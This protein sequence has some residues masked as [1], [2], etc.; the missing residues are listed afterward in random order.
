MYVP[1]ACIAM[2]HVLL[3]SMIPSIETMN[4]KLHWTYDGIVEHACKRRMNMNTPASFFITFNVPSIIQLR[5]LF[6]SCSPLKS[7]FRIDAIGTKHFI[8][9]FM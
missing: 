9:V 1:L 6:R 7:D 4:V 8:A 3:G 2:V 5:K